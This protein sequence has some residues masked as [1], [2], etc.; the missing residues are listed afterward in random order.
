MEVA[1]VLVAQEVAPLP[2]VRLELEAPSHSE[3]QM[4]VDNKCRQSGSAS[5]WAWADAHNL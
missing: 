5:A 4:V 2:V 3:L 1:H